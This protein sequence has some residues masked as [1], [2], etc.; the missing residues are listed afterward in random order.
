MHTNERCR[1]RNFND[2]VM[3]AGTSAIIVI[4]H[5]GRVQDRCTATV[6]VVVEIT[7][8]VKGYVE[9]NVIEIKIRWR[10]RG[11]CLQHKKW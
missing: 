5:Y 11:Y 9:K 2:E 8:V 3:E 7:D 10:Y 1:M 4:N 6:T